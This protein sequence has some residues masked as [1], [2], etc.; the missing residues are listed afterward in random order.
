MVE[1]EKLRDLELEITPEMVEAGAL[2]LKDFGFSHHWEEIL[3]EVYLVMEL[4]RRADASSMD[5][6][7]Y[8]K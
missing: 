4:Q 7:R 2:R 5:V 8:S 6:D 1:Q 3:W